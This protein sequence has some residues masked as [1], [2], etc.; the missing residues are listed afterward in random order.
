MSSLSQHSEFSQ[1][2]SSP[3]SDA[4]MEQERCREN[5]PNSRSSH[6]DIH[7]RARISSTSDIS[8]GFEAGLVSGNGGEEDLGYLWYGTNRR[9]KASFLSSASHQAVTI[10]TLLVLQASIL[11][12]HSGPSSTPW[13]EVTKTWFHN[14]MNTVWHGA[15]KRY[16][17]NFGTSDGIVSAHPS[18]YEAR[19]VCSLRGILALS[20]SN[21]TP[22]L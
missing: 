7:K 5:V 3:Q 8:P 13:P 6:L 16:V 11:T 15:R 18:K 19:E 20:N 12:G 14:Q 22:D 10:S 21:M 1:H 4:I 9:Q 17:R 2:L